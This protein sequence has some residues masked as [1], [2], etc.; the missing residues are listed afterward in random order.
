MWG[1]LFLGDE[2]REPVKAPLRSLRS[3]GLYNH[4]S[5]RLCITVSLCRFLAS[6]HS[7]PVARYNLAFLAN[8][9]V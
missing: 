9:S 8:E 5:P 7:T 3:T 6:R 1:A 4:F 2:K